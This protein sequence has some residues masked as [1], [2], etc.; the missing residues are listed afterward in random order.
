MTVEAQSKDFVISRVFDAP[1]DLVWQCF[2]DPERMKEWWGPKGC[3]IVAS[4]MD[5]RVGG[6]YLGAMPDPGGNVMWGKFVYR[7]ITPPQRLVWAF[8]FQRGRRHNQASAELHLAARAAHDCHVRSAAGRQNQGHACLGTA[9]CD[10]ARAG[11]LRCG[12]RQ[13]ARRLGRHVRAP[14][15]LFGR[16]EITATAHTTRNRS[17]QWRASS[18]N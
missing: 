15:G 6:T 2:T 3:T 11:N 8:V 5:F 12:P 14:R 18:K 16:R 17:I 10:I 13:H 1:R 4:K 7:E 9:Q